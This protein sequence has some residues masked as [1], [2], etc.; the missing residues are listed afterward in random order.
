MN[1]MRLVVRSLWYY[2]RTQ[3][4]VWMAVLLT[5]AVLSGALLV[6]DS[7]DGSLRRLALL[8]LGPVH[9]A[10]YT[11]N[12]FVEASLVEALGEEVEA[13]LAPVRQLKGM[14]LYQGEPRRQVNRVQ[15]LAVDHRFWELAGL[16]LVPGPNEVVLNEKLAAALGVS[17]GGEVALRVGRPG[18][19]PMEAP[20]AGRS[21]RRSA[22]GRFTVRRILGDEELGRFSLTAEQIAPYNAWVSLKDPIARMADHQGDEGEASAPVN[23]I[24]AEGVMTINAQ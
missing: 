18:L 4:G 14:A 1:A 5:S 8:R 6:G 15:V 19:L 7:V 16:D 11:P 20:L 3:T 10:L 17:E 12:R 9:H 2:R 22:R 13:L 23:L 24:L 21:E